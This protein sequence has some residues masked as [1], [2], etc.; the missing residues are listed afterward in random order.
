MRTGVDIVEIKRIEKILKRRKH[1]FYNKIFTSREIEYIE[2]TGG[3]PKTVAGLFA[4]KESVS[5]LL[6]EGIGKLSWKDI[7]ILHDE[8][9]RPLICIDTKI[10][11]LLEDLDLNSIDISISHEKEYAISF[12]IGFFKQKI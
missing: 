8:N 9:G 4:T 11:K 12:S 10:K 1:S 2:G 5:K 7:E 3:S 6:G